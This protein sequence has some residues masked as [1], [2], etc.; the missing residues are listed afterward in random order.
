MVVPKCSVSTFE[1]ELQGEIN[2]AKDWFQTIATDEK[3][4]A[5]QSLNLDQEFAKK[6]YDEPML[7]K[8]DVPFK[9]I[10]L[11]PLVVIAIPFILFLIWFNR[12]RRTRK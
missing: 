5:S 3:N 4:W 9:L 7:S 11:L 6:Y 1:E 12:R 10:V 2:E 8:P